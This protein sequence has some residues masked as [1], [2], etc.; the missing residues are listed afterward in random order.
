MNV[1]EII[2]TFATSIVML[3]APTMKVNFS[4][5]WRLELVVL[6]QNQ[7]HEPVAGSL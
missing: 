7:R 1:N 2:A 6:P 5:I 4:Q 3:S